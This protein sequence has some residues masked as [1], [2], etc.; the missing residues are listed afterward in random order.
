[1]MN[2]GA[3]YFAR[4]NN[5]HANSPFIAGHAAVAHFEEL[6]REVRGLARPSERL[7]IPDHNGAGAWSRLYAL[8]IAL[9]TRRIEEPHVNPEVISQASKAALHRT[10]WNNY[11][12]ARQKLYET[13]KREGSWRLMAEYTELQPND[14]DPPS[15]G[16]SNWRQVASRVSHA[17]KT[18][19]ALSS[20]ER[21][22]IPDVLRR[23]RADANAIS[24]A[25][26]I[27]ELEKALSSKQS[28]ELVEYHGQ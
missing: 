14:L 24:M 26:R 25:Q 15:E 13:S 12:D 11:C 3:D 21:E 27:A 8:F 20:A 1:M 17:L 28:K 19:E 9:N 22:S 5:L 7:A 4:L 6:V 2:H 10:L 16:A 18:I 23:R